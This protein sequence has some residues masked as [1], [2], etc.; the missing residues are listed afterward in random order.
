MPFNP[1][2]R[3]VDLFVQAVVADPT[4]ALGIAS[5]RAL[6]VRIGD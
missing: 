2:L 1:S 4:A 5:T 3:G 6:Q